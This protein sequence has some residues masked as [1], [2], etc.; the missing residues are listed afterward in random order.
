MP[1]LSIAE[2][3]RRAG[4]DPSTIR[5]KLD[6]GLLSVSTRTDG[7]KGIELSELARLYP[8]A[9]TKAS[10]GVPEQMPEQAT[11]AHLGALQRDVELLRLRQEV[12]LLKQQLN[13]TQADKAWLQGQVEQLQRLLPAPRRSLWDRLGD[14][15][16]RIKRR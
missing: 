3:A 1:I 16:E 8:Q 5:R 4:V 10:S 9:V 11:A 12:D 14:L 15:V 6:R 13:Q 2:C 7:T